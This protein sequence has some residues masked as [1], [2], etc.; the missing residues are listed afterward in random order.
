[1]RCAPEQRGPLP[2]T[3][4]F[5]VTPTAGLRRA[6][7]ADLVVMLGAALP[8]PS[9]SPALVAALRAAA[10]RG[11]LVA[12]LCTGAFAL[13]AVG[14]LD[15]RRATTHWAYA[16]LLAQTYPQVPVEPDSLLVID[17]NVATSAGSSGRSTC[18]SPCCARP[19]APRW[20][21]GWPA[22]WWCPPIAAAGRRSTPRRRSTS[23]VPAPAQ[24]RR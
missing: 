20:P 9:P 14:L 16:D 23:A 1:M 4:G 17:G 10:R 7:R 5:T 15:G 12:G 18:A 22:R 6:A 13:A 8:V 21:T 19:T 3:S 2:T 11:A 24:A